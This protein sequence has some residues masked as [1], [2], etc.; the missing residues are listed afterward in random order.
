MV[1][2]I[3]IKY[4]NEINKYIHCA[5]LTEKLINV[6]RYEQAIS[7]ILIYVYMIYSETIL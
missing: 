1:S 2:I 4:N 6:T 7:L 3:D 5:Q